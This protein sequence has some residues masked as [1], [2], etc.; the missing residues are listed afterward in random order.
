MCNDC[1]LDLLVLYFIMQQ[2][3]Y[4]CILQQNLQH[5]FTVIYCY[6]SFKCKK[7]NQNF[8]NVSVSKQ[9][10]TEVLTQYWENHRHP[11]SGCR[12]VLQEGTLAPALRRCFSTDAEL[13]GTKLLQVGGHHQSWRER[14]ST[15]VPE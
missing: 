11:S 7:M 10:I 9:H 2:M 1:H 8:P 5:V 15:A 4:K 13:H 6:N 12:C 3:V 14:T